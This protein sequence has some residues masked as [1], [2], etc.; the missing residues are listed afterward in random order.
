MVGTRTD[1]NP[2]FFSF[3]EGLS[4][5]QYTSF[6]HNGYPNNR[7]FSFMTNVYMLNRISLSER[8][9]QTKETTFSLLR[10]IG[11]DS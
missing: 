4:E 10:D 2:F 9:L 1:Y 7:K 6:T 11:I 3:F 8:S 5:T